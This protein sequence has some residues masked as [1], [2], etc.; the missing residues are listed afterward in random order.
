MAT[1]SISL[2]KEAEYSLDSLVKSGVGSNR[3]DVMRRALL[4]FAE[5]E[6][7]RNFLVAEQEVRDGKV[8]YGDPRK[9]LMGE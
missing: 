5:D 7:V 6:A 3:S 8:L 9:I 4:Q 1:I 2:N